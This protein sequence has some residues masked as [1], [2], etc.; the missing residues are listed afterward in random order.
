ME[1][2]P[3]AAGYGTDL[4]SV[5]SL[6]IVVNRFFHDWKGICT[7]RWPF[8]QHIVGF[9]KFRITPYPLGKAQDNSRIRVILGLSTDN[10]RITPHI[11]LG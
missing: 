9:G 6:F 8:C 3:P 1:V 7:P 11:T 4:R 10:P 5:L 2:H